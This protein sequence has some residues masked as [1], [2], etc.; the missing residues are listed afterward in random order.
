MSTSRA[1]SA[2]SPSLREIRDAVAETLRDVVT[3]FP[4]RELGDARAPQELRPHHEHHRGQVSFEGAHVPINIKYTVVVNRITYNGRIPGQQL[5]FVTQVNNN[6]QVNNNFPV[7]TTP[8]TGSTPCQPI[9]FITQ[10]ENNSEANNNTHNGRTPE[11]PVNLPATRT[12][13]SF[14]PRKTLPAPASDPRLI[15]RHRKDLT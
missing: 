15:K 9:N 8:N 12:G 5:N 1:G 7:K 13:T 2:R 4:T 10:V 6:C 3:R 11:T 14:L